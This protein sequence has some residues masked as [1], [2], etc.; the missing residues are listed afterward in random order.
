MERAHDGILLLGRLLVAALFL[1]AGISKLL[2]FSG[3]AK[4]LAD[5]GLPYPEY[6]AAAAVA[7]E[8]LGPIA[9]VVGLFPRW[10]ALA[11]FA[12][13]AA[14]I[15]TSHRYWEFQEPARRVQEVN[16]FKNI[17]I[18]G[19]LLFYFVSGPGHWGW[20]LRF[21]KANSGAEQVSA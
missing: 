12:F 18:L 10:T 20:T 15:A 9:L 5:K 21:R 17:A 14:A 6:W 2:N 3:F 7:I 13:V 8:V 4:S 1:P 19:G 16:F 11:L